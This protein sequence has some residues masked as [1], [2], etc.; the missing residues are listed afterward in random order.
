MKNDSQVIATVEL[1]YAAPPAIQAILESLGEVERGALANR[2]NYLAKG[3]S[4]N[5]ADFDWGVCVGYADTL[6]MTGRIDAY[7]QEDLAKH[8]KELRSSR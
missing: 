8:A 4:T 6:F 2:L 1:E 5:S 3:H 7:K